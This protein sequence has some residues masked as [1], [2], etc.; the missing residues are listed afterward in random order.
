MA[1]AFKGNWKINAEFYAVK[2]EERHHFEELDV[3]GRILLK[4]ILQE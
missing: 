2:L 3:E 4:W 1:V